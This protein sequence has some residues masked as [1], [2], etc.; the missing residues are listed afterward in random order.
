MGRASPSPVSAD[1]ARG[2]LRHRSLR[3]Q[4]SSIESP[5]LAWRR[6]AGRGRKPVARGEADDLG[7]LARPKRYPRKLVQ[8]R[9]LRR[10][11][12]PVTSCDRIVLLQEYVDRRAGDWA[13]PIWGISRQLVCKTAQTPGLAVRR[14]SSTHRASR[15]RSAPPARYAPARRLEPK[16]RC[17]IPRRTCCRRRSTRRPE[18][19]R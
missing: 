17:S 5:A 8:A 10:A 2:L 16:S 13:V 7:T 6:G 3:R 9:G 14:S 1:P 12:S 11:H 15:W 19:G 4:I 18:F